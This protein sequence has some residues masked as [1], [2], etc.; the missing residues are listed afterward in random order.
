MLTI[1]F[2][3]IFPPLFIGIIN[4]TKAALSGR[5]GPGI[6]QTYFDL[7]RL[8]K[9]GQ[10]ISPTTSFIFQSAPSINLASILTMGLFIPFGYYSGILNFTGDFILIAA[11]LAMGRFFS[12][13]S[14]MD[15]GSSFEGMGSS[16]EATFTVL[17]E[18]AFFIFFAVLISLSEAF[19]QS[20][21]SLN[22]LLHTCAL[23]GPLNILV[24]SVGVVIL[25]ML[26]LIEGSRVPVDDPET[27]L[28]LTMIHEVM[29]LDNSGPDLAM[30]LYA[31]A[32][33]LTALGLMIGNL[34]VPSTLTLTLTIVFFLSILLILAVLIGLI[35]SSMARLRMVHV[36]QFILITSCMGILLFVLVIFRLGKPS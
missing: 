29:I 36:P 4:K 31:S 27:H 10:V 8:L 34:L 17:A 1:I 33:K 14:A 26:M 7:L 11:I 2:L 15:T 13:L 3:I 12:I 18:P 5:R 20:D 23:T 6:T 28:E 16:R 35:E 32:M 30:F 24:V 22:T 19:S 25:F 21:Y 9:K